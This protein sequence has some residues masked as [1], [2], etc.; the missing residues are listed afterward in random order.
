MA[1]FRNCRYE[2]YDAKINRLPSGLFFT[3]AR[4]EHKEPPA[5]ITHNDIK[6]KEAINHEEINYQDFVVPKYNSTKTGKEI[7]LPLLEVSIEVEVVATIAWSKLTQTF[8]NRSKKPIKEATYCMPL[9]DNSTVTSFV[10]TI[11]SD[12]VLKGTVKPK[13]KAKAEFKEAVAKQQVA[14]LLEEHTPEVFETTV[15]NIPAETTVKVEISYITELKADLGGDGV[16]VTIPTSVAPR[17]GAVPSTM[18]E[19]A[20][21]SLAVPEKNGLQIKIQV[22]S[23]VAIT[24][25]ESRTHPVSIEMGSHGTRVTKDIRDFSKKQAPQAFD[26]KKAAATLSDRNACLGKDFVLLIHA[27]DGQ[28]LASRAISEP[29]PKFLERSA[30]MVSIN[31]RDLYTP[32]VVAPKTASEIIFVAD[33]SGSME[34]SMETLKTAMKFFLKSLPNN[35]IFNICSF[36]STEELMW[37]KSQ[38]YNQETVDAAL[39]YVANHFAADMGGTEIELA[40]QHVV[41][42]SE[43]SMNTEIITLTDGELWDTPSLFHFIETTRSSWPNQNTRFFCLGIGEDVSHHLVAGIGRFGGGLSEV[44]AT[45]STGDWMQRV[46]GML[47]AALTPSSWTVDVTLDGVSISAEESGDKR[48]IQAP[49]QIPDLHAFS[50][51]SVYFLLNKEF[52]GETVKI[53]ATSVNSGETFTAE[54]PIERSDIGGKWVHQLA[55]KAVLG[56]LESGRSWIHDKSKNTKDAKTKA[57][58]DEL[59]KL[60]GEKIGIE[61]NISSKWTSFI[62]VDEKSLQEKLSRWYQAG[63]SDLAELTRP[64]FE[65]SY[66]EHAYQ[67]AYRQTL[68]DSPSLRTADPIVNNNDMQNTALGYPQHAYQAYKKQTPDISGLMRTADPILKGYDIQGIAHED[69]FVC[70]KQRERDSGLIT[71]EPGVQS[72][73]FPT[74]IAGRAVMG[75]VPMSRAGGPRTRGTSEP[76]SDTEDPAVPAS[77]GAW[78]SEYGSDGEIIEV[79]EPSSFPRPRQRGELCAT[80]VLKIE[81]SGPNHFHHRRRS[82]SSTNDP[83]AP[84][85]HDEMDSGDESD[86]AMSSHSLNWYGSKQPKEK[87]GSPTSDEFVISTRSRHRRSSSARSRHRSR[88]LS[89][90]GS[91]QHMARGGSSSPEL[92]ITDSRSRSRRR[93]HS[94]L[95]LPA[96]LPRVRRGTY[97]V[98]SR[99]SSGSHLATRSMR[100]RSPS[101]SHARRGSR[102]YSTSRST[103]LYT[104]RHRRRHSRSPSPPPRPTLTLANLLTVQ[105]TLGYFYLSRELWTQLSEKYKDGA[106]E[107]IDGHLSPLVSNR[108]VWLQKRTM[109]MDTAMVIVYVEEVFRADK[110]LWELVVQKA[111]AWLRRVVVDEGAADENLWDSVVQYSRGWLWDVARDEEA[112]KEALERIRGLLLTTGDEEAA[113]AIG[114]VGGISLAE[115]EFGNDPGGKQ[116]EGKGHNASRANGEWGGSDEG[117]GAPVNEVKGSVSDE[118]LDPSTIAAAG[119]PSTLEPVQQP[120]AQTST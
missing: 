90:S 11:G 63:H 94:P 117:R 110:K 116:A 60:E 17:Y 31:L 4:A 69:E 12:K 101:T 39:S 80:N 51:S 58:A 56:D 105:H 62:V 67:G 103:F 57:E 29:H 100:H 30:L 66:P 20:A 50:R 85:Y 49:N 45:D 52:K 65:P 98:P 3:A 92:P 104:P 37:P 14:A 46:I 120:A 5:T 71:F 115:A 83:S 9:Y 74:D 112:L 109:L 43:A 54:I 38:A 108:I 107:A 79:L 2:E 6:L 47:R 86:S 119:P 106:W 55:A 93:S 27:N 102:S 33:R 28:L 81:S 53:K 34:D 48:C 77:H 18:R 118:N 96:E 59:A 1:Y 70:N 41:E 40:L 61:W 7:Y 82:S 91:M 36:G 84:T 44:V 114:G 22:S 35:C 19:N 23:P 32:N 15:G 10:C 87:R 76:S 99:L 16:L 89:H 95:S 111:R 73:S 88:S 72:P 21:K 8:T 97:E 64:R 42:R 68:D 26:P 13:E 113:V 24:K 25:I 75:N 78:D